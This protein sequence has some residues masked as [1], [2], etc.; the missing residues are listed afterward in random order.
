MG[1]GVRGSLLVQVALEELVL[2]SLEDAML[3]YWD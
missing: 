1:S 3:V 2:V